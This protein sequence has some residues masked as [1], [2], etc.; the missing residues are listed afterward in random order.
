LCSNVGGGSRT[1]YLIHYG[2]ARRREQIAKAIPNR[3]PARRTLRVS[4]KTP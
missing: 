3:D 4:K 2:M 1:D